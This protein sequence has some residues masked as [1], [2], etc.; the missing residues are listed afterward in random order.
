MIDEEILALI[1]AIE[2]NTRREI[3]RGL[4]LDQSYALQISRWIGVSQQA[5]NKQ[6][7]LLEKANLILSAGVMP[8]TSGAPRKIYKPTGF[9]TLV[10][11]YSRNFIEVK[12]F[13]LPDPDDSRKD[14]E[15]SITPREM[16][17][18]L[19]A[20]N[21]SLDRI[22]EERIELVEQK[23]R[24]LGKLHSYI[25]RIAPDDLTRNILF[26]YCDSLDPEYVARRFSIPVNLVM[27]VIENYFR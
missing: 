8:S 24:L 19:G 21:E 20:T 5:I 18:K 3:L 16:I 17:R 12:R 26:E 9:S 7:D 23:D 14:E 10:A 25:N 13:D 6:L 15:L 27:Q 1:S 4:I 22:M 2:N 11:D